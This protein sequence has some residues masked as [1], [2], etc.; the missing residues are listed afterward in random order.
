MIRGD[1]VICGISST[2]TGTLTLAACP[3][4]PGGIDPDVLCRAMGFGNNAIQVVSYTLIE[5]TDS[6]FVTAKAH[7]KGFGT[8]TLGASAG[9]AN[10]TLARTTKQS[11]ATS[12]N[13]QPAT[14]SFMPGTGITIGTA[15]NALVFLAPSVMD[16]Q[17]TSPFYDK[18]GLAPHGLSAVGTTNGSTGQNVAPDKHHY[19]LFDWR[20]PML[21]KRC[22]FATWAGYTGTTNAY[23]ALYAIGLDGK[24]GRL[25]IDFGLLGVAGSSLNVAFT[26]T[27]SALHSTGFLML[28]GEYYI[29][30]VYN[31]VPPNDGTMMVAGGGSY[32][33]TT[34]GGTWMG[35]GYGMVE[36]DASGS[37]TPAPNPAY[38]GGYTVGAGNLSN[39]MFTLAET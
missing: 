31:A 38:I 15:A 9:I 3:T 35:S 18:A 1:N 20:V 6:T 39:M 2:G 17:L 5:Y 24:P 21:V 27:S 16:I 8:L 32:L 10:C 36:S 28:P 14:Q 30:F 11:A 34:R 4:P 25:L 13:S 19:T 37:L 23:A 29:D 22:S 12:L 26:Q 33:L 7:E